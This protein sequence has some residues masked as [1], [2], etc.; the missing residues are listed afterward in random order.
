[1]EE[2]AGRLISTSHVGE[3]SPPLAAASEHVYEFPPPSAR[4]EAGHRL[5][6]ESDRAEEDS[7]G[8]EKVGKFCTLSVPESDII[9]SQSSAAKVPPPVLPTRSTPS[10]CWPFITGCYFWWLYLDEPN[11]EGRNL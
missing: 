10:I 2:T 3:R 9:R 5:I 6:K 4:P 8:A 7:W 1:V 11:L